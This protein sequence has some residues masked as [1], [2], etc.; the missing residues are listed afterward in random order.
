MERVR[1][2]LGNGPAGHDLVWHPRY[3]DVRPERSAVLEAVRMRA[4][5]TSVSSRAA[6]TARE[7]AIAV[8]A[9]LSLRKHNTVRHA[10][11]ISVEFDLGPF[12]RSL[13]VCAARDDSST[14]K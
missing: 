11:F 12:E 4:F 3:P 9:S 6:L 14:A 5:S 7:L 2:R 13:A 1:L 10:G 8:A